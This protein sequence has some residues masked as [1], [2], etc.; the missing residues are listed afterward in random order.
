MTKSHARSA[1]ARQT[2]DQIC[3][4]LAASGVLRRGRGPSGKIVNSIDEGS[5]SYACWPASNAT[6]HA[7]TESSRA[8][9]RW[10]VYSDGF[11]EDTAD[12]SM[13]GGKAGPPRCRRGRAVDHAIS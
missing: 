6:I 4:R 2:V 1:L 13:L 9:L 12:H 7:G 11:R 8:T 5:T 10:A 3:R